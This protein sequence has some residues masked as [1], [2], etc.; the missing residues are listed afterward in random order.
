MLPDPDQTPDSVDS[1]DYADSGEQGRGEE[2]GNIL[3]P[4]L[5][6]ARPQQSP[7]EPS[8]GQ[9]HSQFYGCWCRGGGCGGDVAGERGRVSK[10]LHRYFQKAVT[11]VFF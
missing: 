8:A 11:M 10:F 3:Y 4:N 1:V 7:A 2:R 6:L 5:L 9:H